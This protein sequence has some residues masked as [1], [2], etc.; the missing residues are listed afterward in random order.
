VLIGGPSVAVAPDGEVFV[1]TTDRIALA[2]LEADAVARAR[3][4]YPGYLPV[5]ARLYADAWQEIAGTDG[6][7]GISDP[8]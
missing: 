8:A 2:A 4:A 1:E 6:E 7:P 3:V 5:R